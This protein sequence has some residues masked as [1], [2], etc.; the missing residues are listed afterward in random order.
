MQTFTIGGVP[1]H[2]NYPW[3]V[4]IAEEMFTRQGQVEVKWRDFAGGTGAMLK[5]LA[6]EEVDAALVL[7]EGALR[8]IAEGADVRILGTYVQSPLEWG[9]HVHADSP[10]LHA[11]DLVG[12]P[13]AISRMGSGSHLMS[14]VYA[15]RQ[16][17][18][19]AS[20]QF[21]LAGSLE[22]AREVLA[23]GKAAAF[24]WEKFT[25]KPLVDRGEWRRI[26]RCP[27]PWPCFVMVAKAETA[28]THADTFVNMMAI[29]RE[30]M[31]SLNQTATLQYIS[32]RYQLQLADVTA[33]YAQTQWLCRPQIQTATVVQTQQTLA[34][35]GLIPS[36]KQAQDVVAPFTRLI[37]D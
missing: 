16:N 26:D 10:Y 20:L 5:A 8:V 18:D 19:P 27:T 15:T 24:L 11:Q 14:F 34:D 33:W 22:G 28:I 21:T 9:V 23:Q 30:A 3:H 6:A 25:T 31:A 36:I 4:A 32:D 13:F 7:T 2:F 12:N 37:Q 35:L 29:V 1:E 17:W